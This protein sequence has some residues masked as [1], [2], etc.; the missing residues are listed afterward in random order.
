M[1]IGSFHNNWYQEEEFW[2]S[3]FMGKKKIS[4]YL[5]LYV[6]I[7]GATTGHPLWAPMAQLARCASPLWPLP[8]HGGWEKI[9]KRVLFQI[10]LVHC[11]NADSKIFTLPNLTHPGHLYHYLSHLWSGHS[12][13]STDHSR[14][15]EL[16]L[17]GWAKG[18]SQARVKKAEALQEGCWILHRRC[19]CL[20]T[21]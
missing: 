19:R 5:S 10:S 2:Q 16:L 4:S 9:L 3:A 1:C 18:L 21:S 15:Q 20:R 7:C 12:E 13:G 6:F 14:T 11:R 17:M 8:H